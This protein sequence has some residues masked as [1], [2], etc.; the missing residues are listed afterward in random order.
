MLKSLL[1]TKKTRD[2]NFNNDR[3]NWVSNEVALDYNA[4][5]QGVLAAHVEIFQS[6][7][8]RTCDGVVVSTTTR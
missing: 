1:I 5:F 3:G 7:T 4:G 6:N 2:D 8:V